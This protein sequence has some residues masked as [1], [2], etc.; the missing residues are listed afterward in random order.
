MATVWRAEQ[1]TLD[2]VVAIKVLDPMLA[3]DSDLVVRFVD[4]ARI[5]S[6]RRDAGVI[7]IENFCK[8]PLAIVMEFIDGRSLS[9]M[10]GQ[11]VGPIPFERA[12]PIMSQV[13]DAVGYAHDQGVIHRDLKPSNILVSSE[14]RVKVV[15]FGIA[16][17]VGG[18]KLTKTGSAMGTVTYMSPE[19]IRGTKHVDHRADIYS[20][21]VT[22][23]EMLAGRPPFEGD[24]E[25]DFE[26][27]Q[28]HVQ[29]QPPDPRT[30]Y[31]A[32]PE[33]VVQVLSTAL[34]KDPGERY[35][36]VVEMKNSLGLAAVGGM[37]TGPMP[38]PAPPSDPYMVTGPMPAPAQL[39]PQPVARAPGKGGPWAALF[40]GVLL[41]LIGAGLVYWFTRDASVNMIVESSPAGASISV[42][43]VD[44]GKETP[45]ILSGLDPQKSITI[46]LTLKDHSSYEEVVTPAAGK[47][48]SASLKRTPEAL[49]RQLKKQEVEAA[50]RKQ[51]QERKLKEELERR[52]AK[53]RRE[54]AEA[55][56]R[57]AEEKRR[58]AIAAI[59]ER[60]R[61]AE[62]A[63]RAAERKR[64]A[65]PCKG[66]AGSWRGKQWSAGHDLRYRGKIRAGGSRCRG[67]FKIAFKGGWV[68]QQFDV[69]VRGSRI[70]LQGTRI[71]RKNYSGGYS[72]DRVSGTL[73]STKTRFNG[74]SVDAK[75]S[76]GR[77][78]FSRE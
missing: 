40:G 20:L 70:I 31:P 78:S 10:I 55:R 18:S 6:R 23:Y 77:T 14:G 2:R 71:V 35:Q 76:K 11:E 33:H 58:A 56:R 47:R 45:F 3:R 28:A 62:E 13:L 29:Q 8:D 57:K 22:F 63:R 38:A 44:T 12:R 53:S 37:V 69:T 51:E 73:N 15:D 54:A 24:E 1:E 17:I 4:E 61:L 52:Q 27:R 36:R 46:T 60:K 30:F 25:S 16:K 48:L 21:G 50:Q 43:D 74:L 72:L 66:V 41:V 68:L 32:I 26:L 67:A 49:A 42:D 19:Q 39:P 64:L 5:Q 34:A 75:N 59:A 9:A 65:S 7:S